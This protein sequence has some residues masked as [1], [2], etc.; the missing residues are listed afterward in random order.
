MNVAMARLAL[1]VLAVF[2]VLGS[3]VPASA[4][5]LDGFARCVTQRGTTFY[6]AEW[7][8]HCA[9][10]IADLGDSFRYIDYVECTQDEARCKDARVHSFPTWTFGDGSRL[11]GRISLKHLA[12]KTGCSLSDRTSGGPSMIDVPRG[13]G[14][15]V[16]ELP[17]AGG[18]QIIEV[19]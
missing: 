4:A 1:V 18:V 2:L 13:G 12:R 3:V 15:N 5:K 6:G 9:R 17:S 8:P 10:Q 11:S 16:I 7:C 19:P 14:A